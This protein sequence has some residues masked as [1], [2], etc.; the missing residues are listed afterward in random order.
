MVQEDPVIHSILTL[1][2][3]Q[4]RDADLDPILFHEADPF[5]AIPLD[6]ITLRPPPFNED[7][8]KVFFS[9]SSNSFSF[10]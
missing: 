1:G 7:D 9:L 10:R 2:N 4:V 8:E 3:M 6:F 5:D